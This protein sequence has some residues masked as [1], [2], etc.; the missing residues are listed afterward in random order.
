LGIQAGF[1]VPGM[2]LPGIM[3]LTRAQLGQVSDDVPLIS[4]AT[5]STITHIAEPFVQIIKAQ[6]HTLNGE[7]DK[8]G[9]LL[10]G[11]PGETPLMSTLLLVIP[12]S[13]AQ[14]R[15]A[16][17]AGQYDRVLDL[18]G[19]AIQELQEKGILPRLPMMHYFRAKAL[20]QTDKVDEAIEELNK[21]LKLTS[22]SGA[23]WP[24]WQ[25]LALRSQ[26]LIETGESEAAEVDLIKARE[27][28][29]YIADHVGDD[30]L[31]KSFLKKP[32]VIAIL[33]QAT[34]I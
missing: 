7:L 12:I 6:I 1:F 18:T 30:Q 15:Y 26:L 31:R 13:L 20:S 3:A 11:T 10:S 32:E 22:E 21:G 5:P 4:E 23:R 16:D 29:I 19:E 14:V 17:A 9:E 2:I 33:E 24:T 34:K 25:L 27:L 28:V 8:A